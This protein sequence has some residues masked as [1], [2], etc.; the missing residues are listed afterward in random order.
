MIRR[1][2]LADVPL[3]AEF[4]R[5]FFDES[6]YARMGVQ[7]DPASVADTL[8]QLIEGEGV[9]LV[10]GEPWV[11]IAAAVA[12]PLYVNNEHLTG[13]ELFWWVKPE[14]RGGHSAIRLLLELERW[15]HEKGCATF[16]MVSLSALPQ[17]P[18]NRIYEKRGYV[19][20]EQ[21]WMKEVA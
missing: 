17:S 18:A 3:I 2:S 13:Q 1:A 8:T 15:A 5:G 4:G 20:S 11:G 14:A 7:Y 21:S 9:V 10:A 6:H 16:T 12:F 19:P